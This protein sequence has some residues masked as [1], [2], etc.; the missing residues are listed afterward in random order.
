MK[1]LASF[2]I[3]GL[4]LITLGG[5]VA[6]R[7]HTSTHTGK[8]TNLYVKNDGNESKFYVVL[9][10][11]TV[12]EN[13]DQFTR[14]KYD[15]ADVQAK[16]KIGDNITVTTSGYRNQVLSQYENIISVTENN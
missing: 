1:Y 2:G 8:V 13:T 3:V 14:G 6:T 10:N 7:T 15:S 9:D 16:L 5:V 4:I 11:S 12:L